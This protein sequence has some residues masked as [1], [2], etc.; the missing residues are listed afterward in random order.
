MKREDIRPG[1][2]VRDPKGELWN[3][4]YVYP[5]KIVV[6]RREDGRRWTRTRSPERRRGEWPITDT[7]TL[8]AG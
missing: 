3:V 8:F 4:Q 1:D 6:V 2:I 7:S 5:E